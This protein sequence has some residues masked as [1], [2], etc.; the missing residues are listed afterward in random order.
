MECDPQLIQAAIGGDPAAVESLL[1]ACYDDVLKHVKFSFPPYLAARTSPQDVIQETF[2]RAYRALGSFRPTS[3]GSFTG[4]L[5]RIADNVVCDE[6]RRNGRRKTV[7]PQPVADADSSASM[8]SFIGSLE[9]DEPEPSAEAGRAELL[10]AAQVAFAGM[11]PHYQQAITICGIQQQ[12]YE[13]LAQA[14]NTTVDSA[15]GI[16]VRARKQLKQ[17]IVRLSLYI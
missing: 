13:A 15:R 11:E 6:I 4:W 17:E 3:E 9:G 10:R 1:L 14:L 5:K 16:Y 2:V 12:S 7:S 8:A